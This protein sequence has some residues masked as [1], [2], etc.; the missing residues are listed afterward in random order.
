[1]NKAFSTIAACLLCW[2]AHA[3]GITAHDL[4]ASID[5]NGNGTVTS[6]AIRGYVE[7]ILIDVPGESQT[8]TVSV[9]AN[10]AISTMDTLS[11]ATNI[12]TADLVVRPAVDSTDI[13]GD[14]LTSDP[15]RRPL[16]W[17]E[18]VTFAVSSASTTGTTWRCI[19]KTN[20][21]N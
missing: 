1:M 3:G 15:P 6:T 2:S 9:V 19:V 13:A 8:G 11:L 17:G 7:E 5:T 21:E 16:L 4:R 14:A 10:R 12:V 18:S 20:E